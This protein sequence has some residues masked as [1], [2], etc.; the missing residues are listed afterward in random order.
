MSMRFTEYA[1]TEQ[2]GQ[3]KFTN[4]S[5]TSPQATAKAAKRK[6]KKKKAKLLKAASAT[7]TATATTAGNDDLIAI[8]KAM[9]AKSGG[10]PKAQVKSRECYTHKRWGTCPDGLQCPFVQ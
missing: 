10:A 3:R 7:A 9:Q 2:I 1:K 6:E 4:S 5:Q 8:I